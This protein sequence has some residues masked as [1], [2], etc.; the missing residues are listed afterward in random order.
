MIKYIK[1]IAP[2]KYDDEDLPFDFIFR[3]D[4]ILTVIY[5]KDTGNIVNLPEDYEQRINQRFPSWILW[6]ER[7]NRVNYALLKKHIFEINDIKVTNSGSYY[8]LDKNL[9]VISS[10]EEK[11]VPDSHSVNGEDGDYLH[12]TF[13][14]KNKRLLNIKKDP[15]FKEFN[16]K[17]L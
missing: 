11:Y 3:E 8:L 16:L 15:T 12:F 9:N 17:G 4:N 1:I 5:D 13:D 10:L 2:L 14:L 7:E 6:N